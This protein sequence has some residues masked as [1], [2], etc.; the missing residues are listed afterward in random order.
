M[1]IRI[2]HSVEINRPSGEVFAYVSDLNNDPKWQQGLDEA[3]FTSEG[4]VAVGAANAHSFGC[5]C[6]Y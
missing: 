4:P 6:D 5:L 1:A 2:D 3:K